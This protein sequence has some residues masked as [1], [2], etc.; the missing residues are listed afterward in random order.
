MT[1]QTNPAV[2]GGFPAVMVALDRSNGGGLRQQLEREL[3]QAIQSGRLAAGSTVPP[4]RTLAADLGV[5]RS[6]VVEA[7]GQLVAEG[8]LESRQ[9]SGTRVRAV[10]EPV[11][12]EAPPVPNVR[13]SGPRFLNG[14]P[15]PAL[16][17]RQDWLRHY[18]AALKTQPDAAFGYGL[19]QGTMEL[20]TAL[21]AYLGRV[22]GV[23]TTPERMLVCSGFAEGL[24]LICRALAA[25][26]VQR[27]AVEDPCFRYHRHQIASAGLEPVP[28]AVD[29]GGVDVGRLRD[30]DAGAVLLS[31]AHS[32][33]YGAVLSPDRRA[34]L[35][36]WARDA[37]AVVIED[38]YDAEFRYDRTPVGALQ[39][40]APDRVIYG[41][42]T[43]KVLSPALR[44]GW[45]A[46]PEWLVAD[47]AS[48]KFAH[49]MCSE[50]L[51]QLALARFVDGGDLARHLRR[52]RPVYRSRRDA[53]LDAL[54]RFMPGATPV[55]IAAGLHLFVRL[56]EGCPE[57]ALVDAARAE[58]VH[59]E[60][61]SRHFA[62][63]D[64]APPALVLGYGPVPEPT[65]RH[66]IEILGRA[67]SAVSA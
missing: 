11:A 38:D 65:I 52:V 64:A 59:V 51:G 20:R 16:F 54:A 12:R 25:R 13:T 9:G 2:N 4:S 19:T 62:D 49:D 7:Y 46:A 63:R 28:V 57:A 21:A 41:G 23:S 6:V 27:V 18:R 53:A 31:P 42:S 15:D 35:V 48:A 10:E 8:Y 45:L 26:G 32:S 60:G 17:P 33:P 34:A 44:I 56:P 58:G 39:G 37:D 55:G 1:T 47:L 30:L 67:C 29:E 66:G 5:A 14:L 50:V 43:S 36:R 61:A 40:H 3:R 22:R 24:V